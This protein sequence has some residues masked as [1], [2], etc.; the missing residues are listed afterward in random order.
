[1]DRPIRFHE[2]I[3]TQWQVRAPVLSLRAPHTDL[4][5]WYGNS[6]IHG[7]PVTPAGHGIC[8]RI[9]ATIHCY[10]DTP[11]EPDLPGCAFAII[12]AHRP[13]RDPREY[14]GVFASHPASN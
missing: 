2:L 12:H 11:A 5:C 10:D 7:F 4:S 14:D 1:M 9:F 3:D 13:L 8:N 6:A